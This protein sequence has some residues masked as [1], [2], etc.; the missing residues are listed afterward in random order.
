M[1]K[2]KCRYFEGLRFKILI[3]SLGLPLL[4]P[5]LAQAIAVTLD[6]NQF[7]FADTWSQNSQNFSRQASDFALTIGL[8]QDAYINLG[9]NLSLM[10]SNETSSSQSRWQ[11]NDFGFK[12]ALFLNS[13]KTWGMGL[14]YNVTARGQYESGATSEIRTGNSVKVDIG[15]NPPIFFPALFGVRLNYYMANYD[16]LSTDG[17]SSFTSSTT[18]RSFVYPSIYFC[19]HFK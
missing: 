6:T 12:L 8:D 13:I 2:N 5:S 7:Y 1:V 10:S 11:S 4:G 15:Y 17:G 16:K 19:L 3:I 14:T 18:Q 9:V